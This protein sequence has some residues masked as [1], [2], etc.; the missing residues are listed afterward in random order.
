MLSTPSS[1]LEG[2]GRDVAL[3]FERKQNQDEPEFASM[4]T[5]HQHAGTLGGKAKNV[6]LIR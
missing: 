3:A 6:I 4:A 2:V 1:L 5:V